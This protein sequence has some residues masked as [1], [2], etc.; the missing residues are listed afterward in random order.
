MDRAIIQ[1]L[2]V[3]DT[4]SSMERISIASFLRHG[5]EYHLYCYQP[6]PNVPASTVLKDARE[7]LPE[8]AIFQYRD[9]PSFSGFSNFFRYRLLLLRGGWWVDTD[10]VCLRPFDIPEPYVFAS[11]LNPKGEEVSSA[12]PIKAPVESEA[13]TIA[14]EACRAHDPATL[15]WGEVGPRLVQATITRLGLQ[16]YRLPP[17]AFCPVPFFEWSRLLEPGDLQDFPDSTFAVH[18]WNEMWRR[19]R[20]AKDDPGLPGCFYHRVFTDYLR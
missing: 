11:E 18:L 4:L 10:T 2:W 8:S 16:R 7:I 14:W 20:R 3:G 15:A 19:S 1:S 13:M 12:S 9:F 6:I 5:H 17:L